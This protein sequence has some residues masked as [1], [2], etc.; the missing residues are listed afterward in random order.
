MGILGISAS[1][2]VAAA[3]STMV[4][5][6]MT[7][8]SEFVLLIDRDLKNSPKTGRSPIP[9]SLENCAVVR[10][11][12]NH[13]ILKLCPSLNSTTVSAWRVAMAGKMKPLTVTAFAKSSELT[14]GNTFNFMV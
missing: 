13:A 2:V 8:S 1:G 7:I 6:T 11:S 14:S 5:V 12:S 4:G 10:W 9:G 3:G